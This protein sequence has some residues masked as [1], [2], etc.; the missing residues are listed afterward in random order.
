[1]ML[2]DA[3]SYNIQFLNDRPVFIDALFF[4]NL[5]EEEPRIAYKH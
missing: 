2:K 5:N 4:I 1:M 3:S